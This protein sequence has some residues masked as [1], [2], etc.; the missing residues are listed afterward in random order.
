MRVLIVEDNVDIYDDYL[1]RI[2]NNLLPMDRIEVEHS[3]TLSEAVSKI[4]EDWD[5]ILMDYALGKAI[6]HEGH[7]IK[8]GADLVEMRRIIEEKSGN[9]SFIIGMS[10]HEVGNRL[11]IYKGADSSYLKLHVTEM[12]RE[13]ENLL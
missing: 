9:Q 7:K 6:N 8:D 1:F 10:S 5:V 12:A 13:I 3:A 4:Q 11:M 2:F